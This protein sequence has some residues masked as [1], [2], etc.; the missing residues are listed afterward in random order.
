MKKF[1]NRLKVVLIAILAVLCLAGC[2]DGA[3]IGTTLNINDDQSGSRVMEA[4]ID[5]PTF[6]EYF[7]GTFEDLMAVIEASCPEQ[8]TYSVLNTEEKKAV[9]F[10]LDFN[11]IADYNTKVAALYA[12]GKVEFTMADSIWD[13]GFSIDENFYSTDLL[14]WLKTAIL[15]SGYVSSDNSSYILADGDS[16][17]KVSGVEYPMNYHDFDFDNSSRIY[18]RFIDL[19]TDYKTLASMDR[20]YRFYLLQNEEIDFTN[21]Y[22]YFVDRC[23]LAGDVTQETIGDY[24]VFAVKI[25]D[26]T[27]EKIADADKVVFGD[28]CS[29]EIVDKER[30]TA[31]FTSYKTVNEVIDASAYIAGDSDIKVFTFVTFPETYQMGENEY[32]YAMDSY[33]VNDELRPGYAFMTSEYSSKEEA[34]AL[35]Y[36]VKKSFRTDSIDVNVDAST[37]DITHVTKVSFYE[38]PEEDEAKAIVGQ[39]TNLAAKVEKPETVKVEANHDDGFAVVVTLTGSAEDIAKDLTVITG[40]YAAVSY[41]NTKGGLKVKYRKTYTESSG[42]SRFA[43]DRTDLFELNY[44]V[45]LGKDAKLSTHKINDADVEL[46]DGVMTYTSKE[47]YI[48][49]VSAK[50]D[51]TNTVALIVIIVIVVVALVVVAFV[52]LLVLKKVKD[53]KAKAPASAPAANVPTVFCAACGT[54]LPADTKFC[55]KCGAKVE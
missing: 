50:A 39:I 13:T 22:N 5:L 18:I 14:E 3:T 32:Y 23:S 43:L 21:I 55:T 26:C 1:G 4:V 25:S 12:D 15:E 34:A 8:L 11:S 48:N 17:L 52:A 33:S 7:S 46:T 49:N 42:Y 54:K 19:L 20:T 44:T 2:D 30:E 53:I 31:G 45:S 35:T 6:D 10:T 38:D 51:C 41:K 37:D 47:C 36:D 24:V 9:T 40:D 16:L 29:F 28:T 27:P